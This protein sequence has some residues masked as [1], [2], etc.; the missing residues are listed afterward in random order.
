MV[1]GGCASEE[2]LTTNYTNEIGNYTTECTEYTDWEK[3]FNNDYT[4]IHF[5]VIR[6]IRG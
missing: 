6:V 5:R 3:R 2:F 4:L 1:D